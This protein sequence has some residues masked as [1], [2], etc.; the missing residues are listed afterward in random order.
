MRAAARREGTDPPCMRHSSQLAAHDLS[1]FPRHRSPRYIR[2]TRTSPTVHA[3]A[4]AKT[5]RLHVQ[6]I[7]RASAQA[8]AVKRRLHGV[9]VRA[10]PAPFRSP[11]ERKTQRRRSSPTP[12]RNILSPPSCSAKPKHLNYPDRLRSHRSSRTSSEVV[13]FNTS[14]RSHTAD[15]WLSLPAFLL[16]PTREQPPRSSRLSECRPRSPSECC[17]SRRCKRERLVR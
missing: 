16:S 8:S 10:V 12:R 4:V 15:W 6:S 14:R 11:R 1:L 2:R 13:E 9:M 17:R 7:A 5:A 3:M